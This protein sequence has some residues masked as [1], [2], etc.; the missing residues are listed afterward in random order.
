MLIGHLFRVMRVRFK[1]I[2]LIFLTTVA[3]SI[4]VSL[5]LPKKYSATTALVVDLRGA[6]SVLGSQGGS[7]YSSY[8]VQSILSTQTDI[9]TSQRVVDKVIDT[10]R[11]EDRA[12]EVL[13]AAAPT[14][15]ANSAFEAS[16][17]PC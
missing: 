15:S 1:I 10:L 8:P 6:D 17:R 11:L 12:A 5:V 13:G 7:N 16:R 9:L 14:G 2:T 3:T 4:I